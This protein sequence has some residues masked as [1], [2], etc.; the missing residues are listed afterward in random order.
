[1]AID[2]TE[3]YHRHRAEHRLSEPGPADALR[4]RIE[5][6]LGWPATVPRLGQSVEIG[7]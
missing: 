5:H 2:M 1:M 6:E 7:R 4:Q 3:M